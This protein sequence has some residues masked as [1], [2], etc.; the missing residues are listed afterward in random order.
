MKRLIFWILAISLM[1]SLVFAEDDVLSKYTFITG[2]KT[3]VV[4][5]LSATAIGEAP[6]S[7]GVNGNAEVVLVDNE[8]WLKS[9][10]ASKM[11]FMLQNTTEDLT[12]EFTLKS[13]EKAEGEW[14]IHFTLENE[15]QGYEGNISFGRE[16]A[17]WNGYDTKGTLPEN[18]IDAKFYEP[19]QAIPVALTIQKGR[20][21]LYINKVLAMNVAGFARV[22][23]QKITV[24][25]DGNSEG[26]RY[27]REFRLATGVP[28]IASEIL[29]KGKYTSHGVYFDTGSAKVRDESYAVLKSIADVLAG[30]PDLKLLIV[31]H[32]DNVG[33]KQK[34]LRLSQERAESVKAYLVNRFKAVPTRIATAGKGDAEPMADNRTAEGRGLNRRVDFIRSK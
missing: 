11:H 24:T 26:I 10:P 33:D 12:L 17:G 18:H 25:V 20:V 14:D 13:K 6:L 29:G 34:N 5:D 32:T 23:P 27:L 8:R 30:N 15:S 4:E 16:T 3:L 21:K 31:G 19:D 7:L 2:E 22:M 1:G 28:D 9:A